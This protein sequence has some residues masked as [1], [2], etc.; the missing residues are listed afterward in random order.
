V[1]GQNTLARARGAAATAPTPAPKRQTLDRYLSAGEAR[2]IAWTPLRQQVLELLWRSGKAWGAYA[3]AEELR[4]ARRGVYPNSVYRILA[5]FE[6]AR[7]IVTI[8]SSR[9][10]QISPDPAEDDWAVLQCPGCERFELV[11][12]TPQ[13]AVVR[14]AADRLGYAA[15]QVMIECVG[16]CRACEGA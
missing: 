13:A 14:A 8:V 11:P 5:L 12:F 6:Q 1:S 9:R 2:G 4:T 10:V 15:G 16:Q 7:L 3:L